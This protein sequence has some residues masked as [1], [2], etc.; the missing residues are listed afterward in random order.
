V[1]TVIIDYNAGN[2]Q[3]VIYALQRLGVQPELSSD[4][5]TIAAADRVIF[6]GVGAAA[7]AMN[8]LKIRNLD[9][10]IP[11]LTN[12]VLGICLGM[13]IMC[14]HSEEGDTE[15]LGIFDLPVVKFNAQNIKVPHM[16]WNITK[17]PQTELN[18]HHFYF[19]HSFYAPLGPN[20]LATCEYGETFSA[21][22]QKRISPVYNFI[23]KNQLMPVSDC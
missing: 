10:V 8:E 7:F 16:G 23:L 18:D 20:T 22:L 21:A 3:S 9:S 1:R 6:P 5:E 13:Q 17:S 2:T 19:V 11:A 14:K 15:C 12:P 4:A